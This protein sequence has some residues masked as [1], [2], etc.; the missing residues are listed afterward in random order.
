MVGFLVAGGIGD[1]ILSLAMVGK[2]EDMFGE[3]VIVCFDRSL[4]PILSYRGNKVRCLH[5][6]NMASVSVAYD[7]IKDCS[8]AVWNRF[9]C[10]NDG[11]S[12]YFYSLDKSTASIPQTML[13]IY[14]KN[15]SKELGREVK[16]LEE[17]VRN[18]IMTLFSSEENYYSDWN[19]YGFDVSYDDV[20]ISVPYSVIHKNKSKSDFIGKYSIVHDSRIFSSLQNMKS[21]EEDKWKHVVDYLKSIG[22]SVICFHNK[23]EKTIGNS[24]SCYDYLPEDFTFFDFLYLLSRSSIYVGTDSWPAHAAIFLQGPKFILLKGAVS[25]RWDH[26]RKYSTIIRKGRCQSC[27]YISLEKCIWQFGRKTCMKNISSSDVIS[28]IDK[29]LNFYEGNE[30]FSIV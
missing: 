23:G 11:L 7:L 17:E 13:G 8:L 16:S 26:F 5:L 19:R 10:D 22:H 29:N 12:N 1:S 15:L 21:W 18:G 2:L 30:P 20:F 25:K 24:F 14:K 28:E 3:V 9:E 6:T 4:V 27:E